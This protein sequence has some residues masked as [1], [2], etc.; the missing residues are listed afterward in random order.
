MSHSYFENLQ[1][2]FSPISA[3]FQDRNEILGTLKRS[4]NRNCGPDEYAWWP[5]TLCLFLKS[6]I[7]N[8]LA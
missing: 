6:V 5:V 8:M 1:I 7:T 3:F 4:Q 2:K